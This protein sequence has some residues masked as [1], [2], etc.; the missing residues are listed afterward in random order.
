MSSSVMPD[1]SISSTSQT[2]TRRPRMQGCPERCPGTTVI[3]ERSALSS[4]GIYAYYLRSSLD[5]HLTRIVSA[6]G[7]SRGPLNDDAAVNG[8]APISMGR[9]TQGGAEPTAALCAS[10]VRPP[11][12]AG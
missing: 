5:Q 12:A 4:A 7:Y 3:R 8:T 2:V 1:A 6:H 9:Y 10:L 11:L